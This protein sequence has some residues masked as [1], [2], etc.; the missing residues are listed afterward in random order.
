[1]PWVEAT[2]AEKNDNSSTAE[3]KSIILIDH[4]FSEITWLQDWIGSVVNTRVVRLVD[5]GGR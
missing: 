4:G 2:L 5:G 1:V 3:I